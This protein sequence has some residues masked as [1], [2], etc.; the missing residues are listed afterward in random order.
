MDKW[1][2]SF[3]S[4]PIKA[5]YTFPITALLYKSPTM[6]ISITITMRCDDTMWCDKLSE[7]RFFNCSTSLNETLDLCFLRFIYS[8]YFP[9]SNIYS[10]QQIHVIVMKLLRQSRRKKTP[11]LCIICL[12]RDFAMIWGIYGSN[13]YSG[14][15]EWCW[16][17][18]CCATSWCV[19]QKQKY[20]APF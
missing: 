4:V 5:H 6:I 18:H 1:L 3:N 10:L 15:D 17:E 2:L 8:I 16:W 9:L 13:N 14:F 12:T 20:W 19:V 11:L 7:C